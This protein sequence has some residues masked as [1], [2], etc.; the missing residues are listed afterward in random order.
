MRN[1]GRRYFPG[2]IGAGLGTSGLQVSYLP[3]PG[4]PGHRQPK[5]EQSTS[6][7]SEPPDSEPS[8]PG[9]MARVSEARSRDSG[10][11]ESAGS[12]LKTDLPLTRHWVDHASAQVGQKGPLS[13]SVNTPAPSLVCTG[14]LFMHNRNSS[15]NDL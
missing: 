14:S 5:L 4:P 15:I 10:S 13:D 8:L 11:F 2:Q 12:A 6:H 3:G 1:P 9:T 7:E